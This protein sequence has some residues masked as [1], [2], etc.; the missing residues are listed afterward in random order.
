M[1]HWAIPFLVLCA[2]DVAPRPVDLERSR[3][4]TPEEGY[5][6]FV[7]TIIASSTARSIAEG[8]NAYTFDQTLRDQQMRFFE[9]EMDRLAVDD[10]NT[11]NEIHRRLGVTATAE[12]VAANGYEGLT[13]P[14]VNTG[15]LV[16]NAGLTVDIGTR[17]IGMVARSGLEDDCADA[18]REISQGTLAGTFLKRVPDDQM[19]GFVF[20]FLDAPELREG[21]QEGS[22]AAPPTPVE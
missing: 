5:Q 14:D 11:L 10:P 16:R 22:L 4:E 18:E 2:C 9:A 20:R 6:F 21:A 13:A 8:C 12:Q 7:D 17:A 3:I 19:G 1:R 15:F